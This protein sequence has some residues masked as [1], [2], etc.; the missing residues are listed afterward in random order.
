MK[1]LAF[2]FPSLALLTS[3]I[4][5]QAAPTQ[6]APAKPAPAKVGTSKPVPIE[7]IPTPII[8][9]VNPREPVVRMSEQEARSGFQKL[10]AARVATLPNTQQRA[11]AAG[12]SAMGAAQVAWASFDAGHFD[13]AATWFARRATLR[14]ESY[15]AWK[16]VVNKQMVAME[17]MK[18]KSLAKA[19]T[20]KIRLFWLN[21]GDTLQ[22]TQLTQLQL[23]AHLY[24]SSEGQLDASNRKLVYAQRLLTRSRAT[25]KPAQVTL[26]TLDVIA[27]ISDVAWAYAD[28]AQWD[29]AEKL[30]LQVQ[31]M[32]R[33][34]P[35]DTPGRDL[36]ESLHQLAILREDQGDMTGARRFYEQALAMREQEA[37]MR[38]KAIEASSPENRPLALLNDAFDEV[39]I[40]NNLGYI[41]NNM[42]DMKSAQTFYDRAL[43]RSDKF[44]KQGLE[45]ALGARLRATT[46]SN[47]AQLHAEQ[48]QLEQARGEME[49]AIAIQRQV[50]DDEGA[51]S[52]LANL[53]GL[54]YE[55][56]NLDLSKRYLEQARQIA[57]SGQDLERVVAFTLSL[58]SLANQMKQLPE[59]EKLAQQGLAFAR[60]LDNASWKGEAVRTL[61]AVR[62]AQNQ[63][64]AA[65]ALLQEAALTDKRVGAPLDTAYTLSLQAQ[66]HEAKGD[67]PG[68]IDLYK[69]S[70]ALMESVRSTSTSE[71]GFASIKSHSKVYER[72]VQALIKA[73]RGEE[74]F[75]YLNRS[76]SKQLQDSLNLDSLRPSDPALKALLERADNLNVRSRSAEGE[77]Q[78]EQA[79]PDDKRD[80][81][82]IL[83]L[84]TLVATTKSQ[85]SKVTADIKAANPSYAKLFSI[86]PMALSETQR[87]IPADAAFLMYV[88]LKATESSPEQLY[89][90]VVTRESLKIITPPVAAQDLWTRIHAVR[91]QIAARQDPLFSRGLK[92]SVVSNVI[93]RGPDDPTFD[94]A[95]NT[96]NQPSLSDNLVALYDML[97]TPIEPEIASKKML[98]FIPTSLLYYLPMQALAKRQGDDL[99][100]LIEDKEMVYLTGTDI[101]RVVQSSPTGKATSG[102][103]AYGD[104]TGANLPSADQEVRT[105]AQIYPASTG[106]EGAQ[107]TKASVTDIHNLDQRVLHFA[108]HGVLNPNDPARS[109][110]LL[111]PGKSPGDEQLTV[112]D[113]WNLPLKKVDLVV[114]S[115]CNTA[116]GERDPKGSELTTL[117]V[118]FSSAGA[119]S[120]LASLWSVSDDSTRD[121][122]VEFYRQL[123]AGHSKAAAL[124][125]AQLSVMRNPKYR[126]PYFW[127]P[128][129]LMGD[130]R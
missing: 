70:V 123:A 111:S 36:A 106:F 84:Q 85:W 47:I 115:A 60:R 61:A 65:Q 121:L 32:R 6:A 78:A 93:G 22:Y 114:L 90:F 72:L 17:A 124:R 5:I 45:G 42:G 75:D 87:N 104:P 95:P 118:A 74:A 89:I 92:G 91:R 102:M 122:M 100:F 88:P 9:K 77:L 46:Q 76:R 103:V 44:P 21:I 64:D 117:A 51:A 98:A 16:A 56:G 99:H 71:S 41:A 125:A 116:L 73:G 43:Q 119:N 3:I 101:M 2:L 63:P 14:Q 29:K 66:T 31:A 105:I 94:S 120:V 69:Q 57:V 126:H 11:V 59:A 83:T 38:R 26:K 96:P 49:A 81:G 37:P 10:E 53:S 67:L 129:I 109:Y 1:P 82:K 33:A 15:A 24:N 27:T 34:L 68:A 127:A 113:V 62:I 110:I 13:D 20:A 55:Q 7:A 80:A 108:T 48:G 79:K 19:K 97:I 8:V 107:V 23:F 130:W 58:A 40:L 54:L 112:G 12:N 25:E 18:Q 52:N 30:Y 39:Q 128:F 86:Q 35:A 28:V 50:G 4:P